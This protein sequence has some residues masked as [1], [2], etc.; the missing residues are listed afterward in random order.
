MS[1]TNQEYIYDPEEFK[2]EYNEESATSEYYAGPVLMGRERE[3]FNR[4]DQ[5]VKEFVDLQRNAD[6]EA[7]QKKK[8]DTS[9]QLFGISNQNHNQRVSL[10]E[11]F[12][13]DIF[14]KITTDNMSPLIPMNGYVLLKFCEQHASGE[15]CVYR[16]RNKTYCNQI[17]II[18]NKVV[19]FSLNP[20][21]KPVVLNPDDYYFIAV[22]SSIHISIKGN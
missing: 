9:K 2:N 13:G 20:K 12:P 8:V 21:Y 14:Y 16:Y 3:Y 4:R 7:E 11:K 15:V 5:A 17:K 18:N 19:A 10:D 22:V 1:K 6:V